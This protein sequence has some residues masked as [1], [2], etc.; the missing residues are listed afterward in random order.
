MYEVV[1]DDE[2]GYHCVLVANP[3]QYAKI[4]EETGGYNIRIRKDGYTVD[5]FENGRSTR[6]I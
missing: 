3:W 5:W 1:W 4:V 2:D 6:N